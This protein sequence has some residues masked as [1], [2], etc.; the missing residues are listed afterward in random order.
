MLRFT[1]FLLAFDSEDLQLQPNVC[2]IKTMIPLE[3]LK[4]QCVNSCL[5]W[6]CKRSFPCHQ[7]WASKWI[8][9]QNVDSQGGLNSWSDSLN[10]LP[11]WI[12]DAL[13]FQC[14]V[15]KAYINRIKGEVLLTYHFL[16]RLKLHHFMLYPLNEYEETKVKTKRERVE[17][18]GIQ[19]VPFLRHDSRTHSP[20]P[21]PRAK[22]HQQK[23]PF[24]LAQFCSG[25]SWF[26]WQRKTNKTELRGVSRD[27]TPVPFQFLPPARMFD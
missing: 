25:V 8:S 10:F 18:P 15:S 27:V 7:L 16:S 22:T 2:D 14:S 3:S 26:S 1:P 23:C 9:A 21:V 5:W 19:T 13:R 12:M 4:F 20:F 6:P 24:Y 11:K 17:L